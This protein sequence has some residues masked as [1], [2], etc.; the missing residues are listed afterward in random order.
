MSGKKSFIEIASVLVNPEI[1]SRPYVCDVVGYGC[2]SQCCYRACIVPEHEAEKIEAHFDDIL[3]Y[4]SAEKREALKKNGTILADCSKQC[5]K[6]CEIHE[7]EARAIQRTFGGKDFRCVLILKN[8]CSLLYTNK[9]GLRYCA[10]HTHAM[11]K[12]MVWEEFKF[13]DCVQYPLAFYTT[14]DNKQGSR[15]TKALKKR[16]KRSWA[17]IF[18]KSLPTM[19]KRRR[20]SSTPPLASCAAGWIRLE[21]S[22][23]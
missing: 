10:V 15:C 17:R 11:D 21:S 13:A 20:A 2:K 8:T 3:S 14:G 4:L 9:D 19:L 6:G 16:S 1:F 5:P 7:D 18:T 12:G 22:V 23:T